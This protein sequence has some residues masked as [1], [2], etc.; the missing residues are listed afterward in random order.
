TPWTRVAHDDAFD[1]TMAAASA[2]ARR[3]S[4][5]PRCRATVT[6]RVTLGHR[7]LDARRGGALVARERKRRRLSRQARRR[8]RG[9]IGPCARLANEWSLRRT[10]H[11]SLPGHP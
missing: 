5:S 3:A 9:P 7:R 8:D 4:R 10:A 6:P 11:R 2:A 1:R